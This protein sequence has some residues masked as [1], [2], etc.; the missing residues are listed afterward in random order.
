MKRIMK[1]YLGFLLVA[2]MLG[3]VFT[4]YAATPRWAH[5]AAISGSIDITDGVADIVV[6]CDASTA[7]VTKVKAKCELQ[8]YD[9]SWET[10][11][12]WT[13]TATGTIV[14]FEKTYAVASGYDYRLKIT[15]YAY[16]GS[17][18]LESATEYFYE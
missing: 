10:I 5:L 4:T 15:G 9:R 18:L 1:R 14:N 17:T 2:I 7:D 8:K 12:T 6:M 11:K 13:E 16:N 3:T